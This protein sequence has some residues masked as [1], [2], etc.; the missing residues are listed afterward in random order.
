MKTGTITNKLASF[1]LEKVL[2]LANRANHPHW[3]ALAIARL[4]AHSHEAKHCRF[5]DQWLPLEC[6]DVNGRGNPK[7]YCRLCNP[8][9]RRPRPVNGTLQDSLSQV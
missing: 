9:R 6:F 1:P 5:C 3:K 8:L 7:R 4:R 2:W